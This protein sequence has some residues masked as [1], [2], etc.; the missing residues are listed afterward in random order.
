MMMSAGIELKAMTEKRWR[1]L[2]GYAKNIILPEYI[3]G[4][5]QKLDQHIEEF[6]Q[7]IK[8]TYFLRHFS[9]RNPSKGVV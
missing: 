9:R 8:P 1:Q 6:L 2:A 7:G 5:R 4:D 3:D